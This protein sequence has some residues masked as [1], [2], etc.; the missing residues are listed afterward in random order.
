M[1]TNST[2]VHRVRSE[3]RPE[4]GGFWS[5]L[6]R[7]FGV[8]ILCLDHKFLVYNLVVKGLKMRYRGSALGVLWTLLIPIFTAL[9]YFIIFKFVIRFQHDNYINYL[10][11]GLLPWTFFATSLNVGTE[12]L[13]F[14]HDLLRKVP[15]PIH[16]FPLTETVK[17][18]ANFLAGVPLLMLL[19]LATGEPIVSWSLFQLFPLLILLFIQAYGFALTSAVFFVFLRDLRHAVTFFL[20]IWMYATP[21]LYPLEMIPDRFVWIPYL[22]PLT[23]VIEGFHSVFTGKVMSLEHWGVAILWTL[24]LFYLPIKMYAVRKNRIIES[25]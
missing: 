1:A 13:V 8:D 14:H 21:I 11:S 7:P 20:Q 17:A 10:L 9:T 19:S 6:L 12:S 2:A 16:V 3:S 22:N 15:M 23:F 24:I 18:F 25:L 4:L 5:S